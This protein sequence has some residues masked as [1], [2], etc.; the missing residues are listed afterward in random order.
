MQ[1]E[2]P[3]DEFFYDREMSESPE[4]EPPPPSPS[5]SPHRDMDISEANQNE[6]NNAERSPSDSQEHLENGG[7]GNDGM[8]DDV[9]LSQQSVSSA[10]SRNSP[11]PPPSRESGMGYMIVGRIPDSVTDASRH[12]LCMERFFHPNGLMQPRDQDL[13][14]LDAN[15]KAWVMERPPASLLVDGNTWSFVDECHAGITSELLKVLYFF[16]IV[17]GMSNHFHWNGFVVGTTDISGCNGH[18]YL[19]P[20]YAPNNKDINGV[21]LSQFV[22]SDESISLRGTSH[23]VDTGKLLSASEL[24][25]SGTVY[26]P[27]ELF[28]ISISFTAAV[29]ESSKVQSKGRRPARDQ[30]DSDDEDEQRQAIFGVVTVTTLRN[31]DTLRLVMVI[32][33]HYPENELLFTKTKSYLDMGI[34]F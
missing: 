22:E 27:M 6:N 5:A 3:D 23:G 31:V 14:S 25:A 1:A 11:S 30:D 24:S 20:S 18:T 7:M 21:V 4:H 12:A 34:Y 28:R 13:S 10:S 19:K 26:T 2:Q 15:G 29:F 8:D 9:P 16:D 33:I 17:N 32:C